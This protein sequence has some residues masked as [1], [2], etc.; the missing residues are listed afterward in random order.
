MLICSTAMF[1]IDR[2][3]NLFYRA[4][5]TRTHIADTRGPDPVCAH[6]FNMF[7]GRL[8][9]VSHCVWPL[10]CCCWPVGAQGAR[11]PRGAPIG[12]LLNGAAGLADHEV[13]PGPK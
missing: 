9:F 4:H 12:A 5:R 10:C 13:A 2:F 6:S 11:W 7:D 1:V 8:P 3:V